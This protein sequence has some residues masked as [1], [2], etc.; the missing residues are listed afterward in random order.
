MVQ[1]NQGAWGHDAREIR[2]YKGPPSLSLCEHWNYEDRGKDFFGG[3]CFMSQGPL[4]MHWAQTLAGNR[5]LWGQE[6]MAE[7]AHY[8]H[9]VGL[10]M[11]GECLPQERN[12]V[13]L[14]DERDQY[15]LR[16]ARVDYSFCDNDR[17]LIRHAEE[18]MAK[19][20]AAAG[21]EDVWIEGDNTCHLNGTARMG[22]DSARSVVD[23]NCRSWDVPNLWIC[24]GS[25][26]PTV[27]GVNPSL[28]IQAIACR[29]ADRIRDLAR[30][31]EL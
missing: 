31:G 19:T 4:P 7:M 9:V 29:T 14:S 6:L 30:R 25:V 24:D 8:N 26:F 21:V 27:G 16:V 2:S 15:G 17:R 28:T 22:S 5:G 10:R 23:S 3:Y 20:L 18:F 11:V 13:T 1:S 12:R